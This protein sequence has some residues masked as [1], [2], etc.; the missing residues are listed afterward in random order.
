MMAGF[1]MFNFLKEKNRKNDDIGFSESDLKI[2]IIEKCNS[3]CPC[4]DQPSFPRKCPYCDKIFQGTWGGIDAH[5]KKYHEAKIGIPYKEWWSLFC[6]EHKSQQS[7]SA[8]TNSHSSSRTTNDRSKILHGSSKILV[9]ITSSKGFKVGI[10]ERLYVKI[11][12]LNNET[13]KKH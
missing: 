9:N 3:N 8:H 10:L 11:Q 5:Y 6:K 13:L 1:N 7:D 12:N 4:Q 2:N